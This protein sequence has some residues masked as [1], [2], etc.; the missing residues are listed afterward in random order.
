[1]A[2]P[3][4][5]ADKLIAR[6]R[7]E[8]MPRVKLAFADI[9]GIHR[10]KYISLDKFA[11]ST[12]GT[13]GFCDC[14]LG[15][16][17]DDQLYDNAT[18]TGWHTAFPDAQCRLDLATERR[19]PDEDGC[20]LFILEM[21]GAGGGLHPI[22]PRSVLRRVLQKAGAMGHGVRLGFEYEF[23]I[24]DETP[25]TLREKNYRNLTPLSPGSFGYSVLRNSA[26]AGL[27]HEFMDYCA[28]MDFPLEGLHD[29]TGPGV[30]EAALAVDDALRD[31]LDKLNGKLLV[32][33]IGSIGVR[34][35]AQAVK[36]LAKLL[37][38]SDADVARGAAR[39]LGSIGNSAATK[40]LEGALERVPAA[41]QLDFC[42]GLFRCAEALAAKGRKRAA[43]RIYNRLK[44]L[45]APHHV[46][47]G[48]QRGVA[49]IR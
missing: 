36:A 42:E 46:H 17:A 35:D 47:T 23:F 39:A 25:H 19:I 1:M 9:D 41:N 15:W 48:A 8:N 30:W 40:A 14:V 28:A 7:K 38:D 3:K 16:D 18:F 2:N 11:S 44:A 27:F 24:F 13:I 32:G 45:D 33:V 22:C 21:V 20:P 12:I 37:Q 5:S 26:H 34:H 29:E 6:Y 31:A 10:G 4:I 43:L 49:S